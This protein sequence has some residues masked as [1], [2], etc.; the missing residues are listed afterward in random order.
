VLK[1]T[2]TTNDLLVYAPPSNGA[3]TSSSLT[4]L[5][6]SLA[7]P[8]NEMSHNPTRMSHRSD[9]FDSLPYAF[10]PATPTSL[11]VITN[12]IDLEK[13]EEDDPQDDISYVTIHIEPEKTEEDTT[14]GSSTPAII[15]EPPPEAV[16]PSFYL[17]RNIEPENENKD[18]TAGSSTPAIID[19]PPPEA[20]ETSTCYLTR[21]IHPENENKDTTPGSSTPAIIDENPSEAV[22]PAPNLVYVE[23]RVESLNVRSLEQLSP[24]FY[25]NSDYSG[26][27]NDKTYVPSSYESLS[28]S[29]HDLEIEK[30]CLDE[31][32]KVTRNS[33]L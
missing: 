11:S 25:S 17:T 27:S 15:D 20:L 10:F 24:C 14:P 30:E 28:E 8:A 29:D 32:Y 21:H 3:S 16:E 12:L 1:S 18:P 2:P 6:G 19:E 33:S 4:L 26:L 23:H 5:T 7:D 13:P 9:S 22:K 31:P